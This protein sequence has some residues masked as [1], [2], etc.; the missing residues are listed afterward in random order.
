M[1]SNVKNL[2]NKLEQQK[3]QK[4]Q[5]EKSLEL[6]EDRLHEQKR[7]LL[8]HEQAR[9]IIRAVGLQTQQQLQFHI[10]DTTSLALESVFIDP[11]TLSIEFVQRRN[12]T[13]CD[14]F[15]MRNGNPVEPLEGSGGGPADVASFALR[16]ASWSMQRPRSR[17]VLILDEPFKHLKGENENKRVLDMI[18]K[19]SIK[20]KV[21]IIMVSDER[22]S[23]EATID[24]TDRLF[25]V[26]IRKEI[27][28]IKVN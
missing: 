14:L 18:H 2:R 4:E 6:L 22:I 1:T 21:Q 13:E 26:S 17:N 16:V 19:I 27:S 28:Q 9:E 23:R 7:S 11:Y 24:A 25:E 15:F 12:K 5:L 20:L 3:G 10:S 8:R